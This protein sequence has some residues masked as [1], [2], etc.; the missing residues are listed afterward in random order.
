MI[1]EGWLVEATSC[2]ENAFIAARL[3]RLTSRLSHFEYAGGFSVL[4]QWPGSCKASVIMRQ[5]LSANRA[6]E[7]ERASAKLSKMQTGRGRMA[8]H[9]RGTTSPRL[10]SLRQ[11]PACVGDPAFDSRPPGAAPFPFARA[12]RT[13]ITAKPANPDHSR[14]ADLFRDIAS[15][16]LL[17]AMWRCPVC[18]QDLDRRPGEIL[19]AS[20]VI[21]RCAHC[22]LD[23]VF[24]QDY[25]CFKLAPF[26]DAPEPM[27]ARR[28]KRTKP[29]RR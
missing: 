23:L 28:R 22:H 20:H 8:K 21:Y 26:P 27:P 2:A 12:T 24:D 6:T 15:S 25:G 4:S 7:D 29:A 16:R 14:K 11:V 9:V 10:L 19:P 3:S 13:V 18:E 5:V 17:A 1:G